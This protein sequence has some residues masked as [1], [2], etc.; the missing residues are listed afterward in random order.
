[1]WISEVDLLALVVVARASQNDEVVVLVILDLGPLVKRCRVLDRQ[2]VHREGGPDLSH[3][4]RGRVANAEPDKAVLLSGASGRF[5]NG[6]RGLALA[7]SRSVVR[8][9]DDHRAESFGRWAFGPRRQLPAEPSGPSYSDACL[10]L[11]IHGSGGRSCEAGADGRRSE[12][13]GSDPT[14]DR[15]PR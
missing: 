6:Q 1:M 4:L 7:G 12:V 10:P 15:I 14:P 5:G 8:A 2:L 3:L 9:V 11:C 13:V